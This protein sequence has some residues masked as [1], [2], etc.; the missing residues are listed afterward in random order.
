MEKTQE[1]EL[2]DLDGDL[3]WEQEEREYEEMMRKFN[4]Y[5]G[6]IPKE[7]GMEIFRFLIPDLTR[8]T[9]RENV[10]ESFEDA[11][12]FK[13]YDAYHMRY[14]LVYESI[15]EVLRRGKNPMCERQ[16]INT[17]YAF[18]TYVCLSVIPKKNGKNRYYLTSETTN[19]NCRECD[20]NYIEDQ[21]YENDDEGCINGCCNGTYR[22]TTYQSKYVGKDIERALYDLFLFDVVPIIGKHSYVYEVDVEE[23]Y[24]KWDSFD[25]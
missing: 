24:M 21:Y 14:K 7:I 23:G 8:L 5:M 22:L 1:N 19:L 16:V 2:G 3:D 12:R 4:Y 13:K 11:R 18:H 10:K 17:D 15:P 9:I 25:D 6:K 20:R